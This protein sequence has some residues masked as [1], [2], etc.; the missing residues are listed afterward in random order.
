MNTLLGITRVKRAIRRETGIS[1]FERYTKPTRIR[2]RAKQKLGIYSPTI[3]P[4]RQTLK[5]NFPSIL[6]FFKKK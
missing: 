4:I 5:W 6:G 1:T 2:Q 3:T